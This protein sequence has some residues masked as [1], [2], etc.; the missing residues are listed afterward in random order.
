M[1]T[2]Y[3][4]N[5]EKNQMLTP[6]T[7]GLTTSI[8]NDKLNNLNLNESDSDS[9]VTYTISQ[10]KDYLDFRLNE[11]KLKSIWFGNA[12]DECPCFATMNK[13]SFY[14]LKFNMKI[15]LSQ[16]SDTSTNYLDL[17][18]YID[19]IEFRMTPKKYDVPFKDV[20]NTISG[21]FSFIA[22]GDEN[23]SIT[24][25]YVY[26]KNN[27]SLGVNDKCNYTIDVTIKRKEL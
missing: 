5:I 23:P 15:E 26:M 14:A 10:E 16:Y 8:V 12:S 4:G 1:Y 25:F 21:D 19:R 24:G 18:K 2:N 7:I 22:L 11:I 3:N 9:L 27:S 13:N 20:G 6:P 17:K